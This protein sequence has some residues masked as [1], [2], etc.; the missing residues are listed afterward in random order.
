M[1]LR[2][3]KPQ[4]EDAKPRSEDERPPR[5]PLA[6]GRARLEQPEGAYEIDHRPDQQ[7]VGIAGLVRPFRST[8]SKRDNLAQDPGE[9]GEI[10]PTRIAKPRAIRERAR[11]EQ[12][13]WR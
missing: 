2:L 1:P 4:R 8:E 11:Q 13:R 5:R 9:R 7:E 10:Q 3:R 12:R 6:R